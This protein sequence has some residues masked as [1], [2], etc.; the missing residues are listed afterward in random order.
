MV[1]HRIDG[2]LQLEEFAFDVDGNFLSEVAGGDSGRHFSDITD[3]A[4]QIARHQIDTVGEILPRPRDAFDER[5]SSQLPFGSDLASHTRDL[6][7]ERAQLVDHRIDGGRGLE[8]LALQRSPVACKRHHLREV[9]VRHRTD[10]ARRFKGGIN[11]IRDQV[12]DAVD[13]L[14][15][16]PAHVAEVRSLREL[17]LLPHDR[18]NAFQF[19][20]HSLVQFANFI[21]A[22]R[23]LSIDADQMGRHPHGKIAFL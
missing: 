4:G 8:K 16:G 10:D 15:P 17:A 21:K 9:A 22:V 12:V 2:G 19:V 5:L 11:E 18:A 20:R 3:L 1:H 13:R 7:R 23:D 14:V 6:R